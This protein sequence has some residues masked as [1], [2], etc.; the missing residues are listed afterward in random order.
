MIFIINAVAL[1][2]SFSL[3]QML[4]VYWGA[5]LPVFY[6]L[7]VAPHVLIGRP[8]MPPATITRI[9]ADK[10][11]N[12]DDLTAY[13]VKHWMALASPTTSWKKQLNSVILYLT[14]FLLGFVYFLKEMFAGGIFMCM[15]GYVLYQMSLRVDRPRSVYG[16]SDFRDG[17][18]S[19][20][21]RKEWELAAMSI[22]AFSDLYPDDRPLKESANKISEDS[23]VQLLL[24]KYRHDHGFGRVA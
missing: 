2:A 17:S 16:N 12:A 1:Y 14:S 6:A 19:E 4:A 13:I 23:D 11:D 9:L 22:V 24:A 18:D 15:V 10:W 21:A 7:V 8:D 5:V 3:N 20:F